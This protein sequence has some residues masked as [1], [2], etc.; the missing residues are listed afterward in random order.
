M[1]ASAF[2]RA[3]EALSLNVAVRCLWQ[4]RMPW[5]ASTGCLLRHVFCFPVHSVVLVGHVVQTAR[6]REPPL[7][8]PLWNMV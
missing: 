3:E 7:V 2:V 5:I 8:A 6:V 4:S 1:S